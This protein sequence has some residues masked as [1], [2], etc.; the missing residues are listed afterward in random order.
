MP[1]MWLVR[2]VGRKYWFKRRIEMKQS[3]TRKGKKAKFSTFSE[4]SNKE[5][6]DNWLG[7]RYKKI[8]TNIQ[9]K[10]TEMYKEEIDPPLAYFTPHGPEHCKAVE[11]LIYKLIPDKLYR[12]LKEEERFFLLSSAW[13]HDIGMLRSVYKSLRITNSDIKDDDDITIRDQHHLT[14]EKYIVE[15]YTK[16]ISF[17]LSESNDYKDYESDKYA[18][19]TLAKYHRRREN[20]DNCPVTL[21]IRYFDFRIQLLAAYLR[22]AD[23]LHID[24]SRTSSF[25]YAICLAYN[26]PIESKMHWIK[27]KLVHGVTIDNSSRTITITFRTLTRQ[28][29]LDRK[30]KTSSIAEIMDKID[31]IIETVMNDLRQE[32]DSV[33]HILSKEGLSYYLYIKPEKVPSYIEQQT[34][35][36]LL[37]MVT[38]YDIL[39]NPS[40]SRLSEM[41][42]MAIANLTGH[43]LKEDEK[44]QQVA[45]IRGE[46]IKR[47]LDEFLQQIDDNLLNR[48]PCHYGVLCLVKNCKDLADKYLPINLKGFIEE[49][50]L[51]YQKQYVIRLKI[52]KKS[53][54]FLDAIMEKSKLKDNSKI[55][56]VLLFGYSNLTIRAI[57]GFRDKLIFDLWYSQNQAILKYDDN[58]VVLPKYKQDYYQTYYASRKYEHNEAFEK[59]LS[60]KFEFYIGT[61]QPKTQLN[62]QNELMY[63][64]GFSYANELFKKKFTKVILM[65]DILS[66]NVLVDI[67]DPIDYVMVGANGFDSEYFYHSAG[68]HSIIN[69]ASHGNK[70]AEIILVVSS[71]KFSSEQR[72]PSP[73]DTSKQ[74]SSKKSGISGR[75]NSWEPLGCKIRNN[76]WFAINEEL[77]SIEDKISFFNPREDKIPFECVDYLITDTGFYSKKNFDHPLASISAYLKIM[78]IEGI[79]GLEKAK[80]FQKTLSDLFNNTTAQNIQ[81]SSNDFYSQ[82]YGK[83]DNSHPERL[84]LILHEVMRC[85]LRDGDYIE[86][87]HTSEKEINLIISYQL[88]R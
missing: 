83:C 74:K 9:K 64:D 51:L 22:L 73:Q 85:N 63:H 56:K 44:V 4:V 69:L 77:K 19:A 45:E 3:K 8:F 13:L 2:F 61:C 59:E 37:S 27:S 81:V 66:N 23:A 75:F 80:V 49:I 11:N 82:L 55:F 79:S 58:K 54:M 21:P 14:A 52:R 41:V 34:F 50:D 60:D 6:W 68:H 42:L 18:I 33:L 32:L 70:T 30:I 87:D 24:S 12:S 29:L 28:Q 35:T 57:C 67:M 84:M 1:G 10:V 53:E 47:E 36:D 65:P 16:F 26:I 48:R 43:Y 76:Q 39:R 20:I 40:S 15:N 17:V 71:D 25:A 86:K 78:R 62:F 46:Q 5:Y 31:Y 72:E 88:P 38:N 7:Y